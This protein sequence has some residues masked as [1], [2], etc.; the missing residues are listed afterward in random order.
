MKTNSNILQ[1][2]TY[3]PAASIRVREGDDGAPSRT[4]EG[5]ALKFGVRSRLLSDWWD[6]Y[7]EILEPGSVTRE[8]LDAQDIKLTLFHDRQQIL[9]RSKNGTGTLHY[10]VD[11]VGVRFWAEMPNTADGDKALELVARGDID[12]CSFMYSTDEEPTGNA[13]GYEKVDEDDGEVYL[14]H[15]YRIEHVYDYTLTPDPAYPQTEVAR[16]DMEHATHKV[17]AAHAIDEARKRGNVA[18]IRERM[19]SRLL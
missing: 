17:K 3:T 11:D 19:K 13:V 18:A 14:R 8:M 12:G 16:R 4:I 10:E 7:Y 15:V 1:R 6:Y 2:S 9:A 5:Y